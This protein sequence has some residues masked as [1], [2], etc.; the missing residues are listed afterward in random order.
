MSDFCYGLSFYNEMGS[1]SS[2]KVL[3]R[4]ISEISKNRVHYESL[5]KNL[6]S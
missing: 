4:V 5:G 3:K 6:D 1:Q 2:F